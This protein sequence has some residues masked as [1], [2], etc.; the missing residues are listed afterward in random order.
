[1]LFREIIFVYS[2]NLSSNIKQVEQIVTTALKILN[3]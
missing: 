1:M 2:Q 3:G